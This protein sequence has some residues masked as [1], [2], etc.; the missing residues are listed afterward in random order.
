MLRISKPLRKIVSDR[1]KAAAAIRKQ[2]RVRNK[3]RYGRP[4]LRFEDAPSWS[5]VLNNMIK[6]AFR[7]MRKMGIHASTSNLACCGSCCARENDDKAQEWVAY[8]VQSYT[9]EMTEPFDYIFMR[10]RIES[11][12]ET[13]QMVV[14]CFKHQGFIVDWD[15]SD[16]KTILLKLPESA[17]RHWNRLRLAWKTHYI[18]HWWLEEAQKKKH[19]Q[20]GEIGMKMKVRYDNGEDADDP[21]PSIGPPGPTEVFDKV[22]IRREYQFHT[23]HLGAEIALKDAAMWNEPT[24]GCVPG[25]DEAEIESDGYLYRQ[26]CS[27]LNGG[28][29]RRLTMT[30][31]WKD[32]G[33][34]LSPAELDLVAY[35]GQELPYAVY[36]T[37]EQ[38]TKGLPHTNRYVQSFKKRGWFTIAEVIRGIEPFAITNATLLLQAKKLNLND[39]VVFEWVD[40]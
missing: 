30:P 9:C 8:H 2:H 20:D 28:R 32:T 4:G 33:I 27:Y 26:A 7:D 35:R 6:P 36:E 24:V 21:D 29:L 39:C 16:D 12:M 18:F 1:I 34:P 10:H 23:L 5:L 19:C 37:I 40:D 15:F 17:M 13:K 11:G 14:D 25:L 38:I 31:E 22:F 3:L